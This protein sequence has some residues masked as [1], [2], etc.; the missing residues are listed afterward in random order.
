MLLYIMQFCD[1]II[2]AIVRKG[3]V[4]NNLKRFNFVLFAELTPSKH[5]ETSSYNTFQAK[6]FVKFQ[7]K[8]TIV[9]SAK[10]DC[11]LTLS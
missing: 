9:D 7:T 6:V 8:V 2:S 1:K 4:I 5:V 10:K 11:P 3:T